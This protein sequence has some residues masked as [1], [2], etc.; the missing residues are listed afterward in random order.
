[1]EILIEKEAKE[2]IQ[3]NSQDNTICVEAIV[4]GSG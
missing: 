1:M 2:F 3:K 4:A